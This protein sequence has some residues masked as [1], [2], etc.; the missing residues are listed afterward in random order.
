MSH[1]RILLCT[2]RTGT[3]LEPW[4]TRVWADSSLGRRRNQWW[5]KWW[6][7]GRPI[8]CLREIGIRPSSRHGCAIFRRNVRS[9]SQCLRWDKPADELRFSP[10][11]S[12]TAKKYAKL[13]RRFMPWKRRVK[14]ERFRHVHLAFMPILTSLRDIFIPRLCVTPV[15]FTRYHNW[16]RFTTKIFS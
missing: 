8:N 14:C 11:H 16:Y 13:L 15:T 2:P 5:N 12:N 4:R 3:S 9:A 6:P 7:L 10:V 1:L